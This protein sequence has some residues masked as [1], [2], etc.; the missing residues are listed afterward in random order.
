MVISCGEKASDNLPRRI[1]GHDR[2]ILRISPGRI[3]RFPGRFAKA[4][5]SR[6]SDLRAR[7]K[8]IRKE[9]EKRSGQQATF[10]TDR[11]AGHRYTPVWSQVSDNSRWIHAPGRRICPAIGH[12]AIAGVGELEKS[13]SRIAMSLLAAAGL[14]SGCTINPTPVGFEPVPEKPGEWRFS[15]DLTATIVQKLHCE[16]RDAM[17]DIAV[18]F[19]QSSSDFLDYGYTRQILENYRKDPTAITKAEVWDF[20]PVAQTIAS[21]FGNSTVKMKFILTGYESNTGTIQASLNPSGGT[22][23]VS[24]KINDHSSQLER[25]NKR[26]I[27]EDS[28]SFYKLNEIDCPQDNHQNYRFAYRLNNFNYPLTG[29][30]DLIKPVFTF[31]RYTLSNVEDKRNRQIAEAAIHVA[32]LEIIKKETKNKKSIEN[33]ISY[34]KSGEFFS[35]CEGDY[36][37]KKYKECMDKKEKSKTDIKETV[38]QFVEYGYNI[39][40][41]KL[42][43]Y[44][45]IKYGA[46]KLYKDTIA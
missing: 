29:N 33:Q 28:F 16:A 6:H 3:P 34:F 44:N 20:H 2:Q 17:L 11:P 4:P 27:D 9:D 18:G 38:K 26:T 41:C 36:E 40:E 13:G 1:C 12:L 5:I 21:F 8:A 30:I 42:T 45:K 43:N 24:L 32:S 35:I 7:T 14:I 37:D 31:V 46:E 19:L 15:S 39:S 22:N 10:G 25:K 23:P